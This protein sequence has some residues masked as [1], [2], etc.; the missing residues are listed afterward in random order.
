MVGSPQIV[1]EKI[2]AGKGREIVVVSVTRV[3]ACPEDGEML[4][5][6]LAGRKEIWSELDEA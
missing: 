5:N 3:P 4:V 1:S 6:G 2:S